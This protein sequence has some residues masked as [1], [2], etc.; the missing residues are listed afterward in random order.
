MH[1]AGTVMLSQSVPNQCES[2]PDMQSAGAEALMA[3]EEIAA[4]PS[5]A[6]SKRLCRFLRYIVRETV[7]GRGAALKEYQIG[8]DVCERPPDFDP[9]LDAIVRVEAGRLR[10]KLKQ[11]YDGPG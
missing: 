8:V 1:K 7:E 2:T 10:A 4:T 6:C 5:F 3:V 11:Y 9:K